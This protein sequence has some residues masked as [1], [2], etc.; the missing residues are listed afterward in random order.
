MAE[1]EKNLNFIFTE[2]DFYPDIQDG[3]ENGLLSWRRGFE[4]NRYL[5]L[6]QMGFEQRGTLTATGGFLYQVSNAFLKCLTRLPELELAREKAE[7]KL[8]DEEMN[9][10]L[11]SVPFAIGA[12][13]VTEKWIQTVFGRL[14]DVFAGEIRSYE[15][16][17]A[18]Y[19][20]EKTQGLHVPER[21]FFHLVE[22]KDEEY[23]FAF[24][25]TYA[26]KEDNGRIRH[27]PLKYALTEY[28]GKREKLLELL[29]C[30]NRAAEVSA[31]IAGF[32]ESGEMFHPL[33]LTVQEGYTFLKDVEAIE[34]TGILCRIPNWWKKKSCECSMSVK[35]G[36]KK[37]SMLGFD[38]L[39][40][41]QPQLVVDG[42]PLTA[43]DI[44]ALLEQTEGLAF[45][46]G[47]W[48]EVNHARLR[49]LL[50]RMEELPE[51]ITL[52][53]AMQMELGE[54]GTAADADVGPRVTNGEWLAELF[55]NLRKPER[56][57]KATLPKT[58]HATL[59]PYQ[60]NGY[61]WLNYMDELG[62]GACLADDMG[63]GK[64]IQVLAYL[65]KLRKK[66]RNAKVLL[67]VPASLLDNWQKEA[68]KF[69][70][71]MELLLLHGKTAPL[72][73]E[74][75]RQGQVFLT[76]T[77][78]GMAARMES[79]RKISWDCLILDEAQAIKNPATKQTRAVKQ[80]PARMRI[81]MTGTP[82][83]ND[84]TN[85]WSLFDFLNRGLLGSSTEFRDYCKKLDTNPEGYQKL[86][87]MVSPFMLR[88]VKTDKKIIA[89]LPEKV[90]SIDYV[91]LS[92]KQVVLYRKVVEDMQK[93]VEES[94]G[95]ERR[96]IV[97]ATITKLKQICNHPDQYL[98][99][100]AY[101]EKDSGKLAMLREI[102][103]TIYEKRERVIVFTQFK[104]IT[105]VLAEFLEDVFGTKGYVLHG[106][107]PVKQRGKIV[108]AFQG[109]KYVPFLV[110]SVKAGGTGLNLTKANHVIHFDRWW[111]PAVENQATDRAFRIGQKKNVIVHKLVCKGTVEEKIDA[112]IQSK[113]EL[114]EN[115][116]GSG[117]EKWI[118]EL[119]NEELMKMLRLDTGK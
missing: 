82:I 76:I 34:K 71:E 5:A 18:M 68:E 27:M 13:Y 73:E 57:R 118:T 117:T 91:S 110:I 10:L 49:E 89:D 41:V 58:L 29:S 2:N 15:G 83:E 48:V 93:K 96:G 11:F 67:I 92:K 61:T 62:F 100:T 109:E 63:L 12:E 69:V 116:I 101:A 21:I 47:K 86:K 98:G 1:T 108:E 74:Q 6:Y 80:I 106:G 20:A 52:R 3:T 39:V 113:T 43:E 35:L 22:Q 60:R 54:K 95:I 105:E 55:M 72:L 112:M 70:P 7:P 119:S 24:L 26:T 14:R 97:L 99:Q 115:V 42:V 38:S 9:G 65:E 56:M 104:E 84:L 114:A 31:L 102:C 64:T 16:T 40:S 88:R 79:L 103:N 36:E 51:E 75:L 17:V 8:L 107:T 85:L 50:E 4:E 33:R 77:T 45:L 78:Y 94:E 111:N 19:L 53:Q 30:L 44:R 66:D 81:A 87:T 37:P 90:E 25:A 23:P 46:K 59:R 32:V 28:K